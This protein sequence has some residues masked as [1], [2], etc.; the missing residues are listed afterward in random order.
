MGFP[1]PVCLSR[2]FLLPG[3]PILLLP[4]SNVFSSEK[5][6]FTTPS[7]QSEGIASW[8]ACPAKKTVPYSTLFCVHGGSVNSFEACLQ[9]WRYLGTDAGW[10]AS[11]CHP[12]HLAQWKTEETGRCAQS[13]PVQL[14]EAGVQ[15]LPPCARPRPRPPW[16]NPLLSVALGHLSQPGSPGVPP[17]PPPAAPPVP[18][19]R[20]RPLLHPVAEPCGAEGGASRPMARSWAGRRW[21]SSGFQT[22]RRLAGGLAWPSACERGAREGPLPP[23]PGAW[24][25]PGSACW[26]LSCRDGPEVSGRAQEVWGGDGAG[27]ARYPED[28]G[29]VPCNST[30]LHPHWPQAREPRLCSHVM[31]PGRRWRSW[32]GRKRRS[33]PGFPPSLF[34]LC[35]SGLGF[36]FR[37][38]P[39]LS[40][41]L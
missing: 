41:F 16:R 30:G 9:E 31:R 1:T 10:V 22:R 37:C 7:S 28:L 20:A 39:S 21:E 11:E 25:P 13:G 26:R 40:S 29:V 27:W 12:R 32:A 5:P 4:S 3:A 6:V 23:C 2:P 15:E 36:S 24:A 14:L 34:F 18:S 33:S 38:F 19:R 8:F 35:F 17:A